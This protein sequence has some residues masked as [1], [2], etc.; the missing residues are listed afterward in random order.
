MSSSEKEVP[1]TTRSNEEEASEKEEEDVFIVEKVL[2]KRFRNGKLQYLLKWENYPDSDNTWE[3]ASNIFCPDL[4]QEFENHYDKQK[5]SE[6]A[7]GED[8]DKEVRE[9]SPTVD[10]TKTPKAIPI[11]K[12]KGSDEKRLED[13][14]KRGRPKDSKE[15]K[16]N[17]EGQPSGHCNWS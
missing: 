5:K 17:E 10:E 12:P 16:K 9:P 3:F 7:P 6:S 13:K 1:T 2:D 4:I 14:K 15:S 8:G 11:K